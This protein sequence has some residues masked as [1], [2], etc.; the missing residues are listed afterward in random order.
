MFVGFYIAGYIFVQKQNNTPCEMT[1]PMSIFSLTIYVTYFVL[2]CNFFVRTYFMR[3][4]VAREQ[5]NLDKK[6]PELHMDENG[7][8][9]KQ[10]VN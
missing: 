9:S 7:N 5:T 6:T 4:K 8:L 1:K 10:K 3:K 2:F